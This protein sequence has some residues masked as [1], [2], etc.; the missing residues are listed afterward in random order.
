[1]TIVLVSPNVSY[2][3][4]F[5]IPQIRPGRSIVWSA[6]EPLVHETAKVFR[7]INVKSISV[8]LARHAQGFVL[9]ANR[10]AI[11]IVMSRNPSYVKRVTQ[12]IPFVLAV[13]EVWIPHVGRLPAAAAMNA[14]FVHRV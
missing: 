2:V 5:G 13:M 4:T 10:I 7:R 11:S 6:T 14:D 8:G 12:S 9:A 3:A 1:M